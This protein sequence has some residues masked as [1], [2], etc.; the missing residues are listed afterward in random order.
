MTM[1]IEELDWEIAAD[2]WAEAEPRCPRKESE[3][4]AELVAEYLEAGGTITVCD[5]QQSHTFTHRETLN[6]LFDT[7][8][9]AWSLKDTYTLEQRAAHQKRKADRLRSNQMATDKVDVPKVDAALGV[10]FVNRSAMV[11]Y[12][13][14][15]NDKV[16]RLLAVYFADDPRAEGMQRVDR[17]TK[18]SQ[19]DAR[20][21]ARIKEEYAKGGILHKTDLLRRVG[22]GLSDVGL[23]RLLRMYFA[24]HPTTIEIR[25]GGSP[26]SATWLKRMTLRAEQLIA[27][28]KNGRKDLGKALRLH[29]AEDIDRFIA[30]TGLPFVNKRRVG[31]RGSTV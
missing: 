15:S 3:A 27:A 21:I 2:E 13:G 9:V 6:S 17:D 8:N 19:R 11:D 4:L 23:N 22:G 1:I 7:K 26:W 20:Y 16:C 28:G 30:V 24:N 10:G 5:P 18:A 29:T 14:M 25:E 12:L 31:L